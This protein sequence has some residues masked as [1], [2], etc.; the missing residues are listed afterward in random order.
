MIQLLL[1]GKIWKCP[2]VVCKIF[3]YGL[4]CKQIPIIFQLLQKHQD[5]V[6]ED[7]DFDLS[8]SSSKTEGLICGDGDK[9]NQ[10]RTCAVVMSGVSC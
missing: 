7:L 5:R 6:H 2:Y 9:T 1:F 8:L 10:V 3:M 4:L